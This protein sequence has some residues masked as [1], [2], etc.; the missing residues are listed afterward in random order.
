MLKCINGSNIDMDAGGISEVSFNLQKDPSVDCDVF[1]TNN[2]Y[3]GKTKKISA[4]DDISS[5]TRGSVYY[6]KD[7]MNDPNS[8]I[9]PY[10]V[11]QSSYVDKVSRITLL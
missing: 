7:H 9:H 4:D 6:L 3:Y 5:L 11:I 1:N 2:Y 8:T 10:I